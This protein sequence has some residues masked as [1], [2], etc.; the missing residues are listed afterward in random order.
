VKIG[1]TGT[2]RGMTDPQK[3][4]FRSLIVAALDEGKSEFHH[5][6]CIGADTDAHKIAADLKIKIIAHPPIVK[7]KQTLDLLADEFRPPAPY[8][9]RNHAIVDQTEFLIATPGENNEVIRSGTWATVRYAI[10]QNRDVIII[11]PDGSKKLHF[12]LK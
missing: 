5:G 11:F 9:D 7:T 12:H 1:F 10:K 8:L 3:R 2:Q 6:C 4:A